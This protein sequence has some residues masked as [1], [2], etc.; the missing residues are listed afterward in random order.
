LIE[1]INKDDTVLIYDAITS[2]NRCYILLNAAQE[3]HTITRDIPRV[4]FIEV[5]S[6][7]SNFWEAPY[8][9]K[10]NVFH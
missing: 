5:S 1:T 8:W 4:H 6:Q 3:H 7:H 10:W 2:P 9:F